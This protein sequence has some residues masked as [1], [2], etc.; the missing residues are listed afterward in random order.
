MQRRQRAGSLVGYVRY[1]DDFVLLA[2]TRWQ[3]RRAIAEV[4]AVIAPLGLRLHPGKR[5]IGRLGA[6]GSGRGFDFLGY[7]FE[8]GRR[9]RPSRESLRRLRERARRLHEHGGDDER[10]RLY[11]ER[12]WVWIHAGLGE[13]RAS[14]AS[15]KGGLKRHRREVLRYLQYRRSRDGLER[16]PAERRDGER[17][18]IE[19]CEFEFRERGWAVR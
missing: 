5:Y 10:L 15:R 4:H 8:R 11:A 19:L 9:L 7:R 6:P 13:G 2:R 14:M 16:C 17:R 3:L 1:M 12:W 18:G